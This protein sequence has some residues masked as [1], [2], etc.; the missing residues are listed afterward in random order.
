MQTFAKSRQSSAFP[1][2]K[3]R[4]SYARIPKGKNGWEAT[5]KQPKMAKN[6]A[7]KNKEN[8]TFLWLGRVSKTRRILSKNRRPEIFPKNGRF[9]AK[10]TGALLFPVDRDT[11]Q[12]F[13][14]FQS[15]ILMLRGCFKKFMW[16]IEMWRHDFFVPCDFH[17][18]HVYVWEESLPRVL[19]LKKATLNLSW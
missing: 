15:N 10:I 12:F 7:K 19:H 16:C 9:S 6:H 4:Q 8:I 3:L 2:P 14:C 11:Y 1:H 5:E 13:C 18:Q 17:S